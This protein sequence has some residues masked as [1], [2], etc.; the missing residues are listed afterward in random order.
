MMLASPDYKNQK[1]P[2]F[3][4]ILAWKPLQEYHMLL[5]TESSQI[6]GEGTTER[7]ENWETKLIEGSTM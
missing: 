6:Q 4:N 1:L 3:L 2:G 7:Q 5:V